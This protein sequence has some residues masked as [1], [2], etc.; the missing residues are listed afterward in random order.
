[1][2]LPRIRGSV[3]NNNGFRIGWLDLLTPSSTSPSLTIN[4]NATANLSTSQI[5]RTRYPF[6][7]NGF[8]TRT[9]T[10]THSDVF[11]PFPAAVNS[12]DS[13]QFP[14]NYCS[15]LLQ[16]LSAETEAYWHGHSWHRTPLGPMPINL[17]NVKTVA[18]FFSSLFLP[19]VKVGV[20]FL[21]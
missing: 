12:E 7:I 10:S 17:F 1:M 6:P 16:Q 18:F 5:T 19:I 14:S 4:Y 9:I 11:L 8:I 2:Y 13:T 21:I 20:G 3:T 15:V